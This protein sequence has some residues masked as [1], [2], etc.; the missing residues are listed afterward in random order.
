MYKLIKIISLH[1][2]NWNKKPL[3]VM[4]KTTSAYR[5]EMFPDETQE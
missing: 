2:P 5:R 3:P 1:D 4:E